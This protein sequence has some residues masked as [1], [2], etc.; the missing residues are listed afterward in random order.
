MADASYDPRERLLLPVDVY[1]DATKHLSS[2]QHG[3]LAMLLFHAWKNDGALPEGDR[4]LAALTKMSRAQ[5]M[6]AKPVVMPFFRDGLP[7]FLAGEEP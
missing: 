7:T 3:A 4:E 1:L 2:E 5:W 6:N